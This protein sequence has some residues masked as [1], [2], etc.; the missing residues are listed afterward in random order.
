MSLNDVLKTD[1]AHSSDLQRSPTGDIALVSGLNNMRQALFHRLI[2]VPGSLIH[3]PEYGVGM[4]LY[5]GRTNSPAV[6][7]E[8]ALKIKEQFK[9]D[10]RVVNV[11]GVLFT[12]YDD[13]PA[14]LKISVRIQIVGYNEDVMDFT[15]FADGAA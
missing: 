11:T 14:M 7:R 4:P 6:Q 2:T 1:I 9:R 3:R 12:N 13:N 15:P 5:Q 10:P 8:I